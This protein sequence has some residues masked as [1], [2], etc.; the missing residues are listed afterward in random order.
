MASSRTR[1]LSVDEVGFF[2]GAE[3]LLEV[4]FLLSPEPR[5]SLGDSSKMGLRVIPAAKLPW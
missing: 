1:C 5:Q 3:K 4:W 2:E